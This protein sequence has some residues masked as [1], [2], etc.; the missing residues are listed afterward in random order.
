MIQVETSWTPERLKAL[1]KALGAKRGCRISQEAIS[2]E[3][4]VSTFTVGAWE[5]GRQEP[6]RYNAVANL[7]RLEREAGIAT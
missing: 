5:R 1:R 2:R 4:G 6:A 3:C 7:M